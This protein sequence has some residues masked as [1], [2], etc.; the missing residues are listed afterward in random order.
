MKVRCLSESSD[1]SPYNGSFDR[2]WGLVQIVDGIA[3][4]T[5]EQATEL[6]GTGNFI[7][8]AALPVEAV[9]VEPT[10]AVKKRKG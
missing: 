7:H 6:V 1:G 8:C 9:A 10:P 5:A 3:D 4:V 2:G